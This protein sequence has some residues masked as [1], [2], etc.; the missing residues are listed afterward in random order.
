VTEGGNADVQA[1]IAHQQGHTVKGGRKPERT[2][3]GSAGGTICSLA[4]S[5]DHIKMSACNNCTCK[6]GERVLEIG[7]GTGHALVALARSV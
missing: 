2:T 1:G 3:I 5:S 7:F 6:E 4:A